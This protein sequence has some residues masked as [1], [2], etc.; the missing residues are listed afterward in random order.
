MP[1]YRLSR[2]AELD[3][4]EL[5]Q[6]TLKTWGREALESYRAGLKQHFSQLAAGKVLSK[7]FS[8]SYPQLRYSK[9]RHYFIF[10]LHTPASLMIIGVIHE[11]R[12]IVSQL[13]SRL[14]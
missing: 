14:I 8:L 5:A 4:R 12:D 9:Y 3:L 10:H 7:R 13:D 6:Y 11:K 1:I 2:D